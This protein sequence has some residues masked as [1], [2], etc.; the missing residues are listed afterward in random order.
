[1]QEEHGKLKTIYNFHRLSNAKCIRA[2]YNFVLFFNKYNTNQHLMSWH[3]EFSM[4]ILTKWRPLLGRKVHKLTKTI[5]NSEQAEKLYKVWTMHSGCLVHFHYFRH[6]MQRNAYLIKKMFK[7]YIH[8]IWMY[9]SPIYKIY[10]HHTCIYRVLRG[11]MY[12]IINQNCLLA[13]H[14]YENLISIKKVYISY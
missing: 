8:S 14:I 7:L 12:A 10:T 6:F 1:M 4:M 13:W 5:T 2:E 3:D 9:E 11:D